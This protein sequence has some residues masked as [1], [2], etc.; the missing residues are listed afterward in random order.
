MTNETTIRRLF[1]LLLPS[2]GFW[3]EKWWGEL[4]KTVDGFA[5]E[6]WRN[7]QRIEKIRDI[8]IPAKSDFIPELEKEFFT[9]IGDLTTEERRG[10]IYARF[11]LIVENKTR[12]EAMQDILRASGFD[13]VVIRTLGSNG[14]NESPYDFFSDTG[15]AYWGAEEA[16]WGSE[17]FLYGA[18][19][20]AGESEL[21]TNGGSIEYSTS[22][23]GAIIELEPNPDYWG[24][25]FIIEGQAGAK[26]DVPI[27]QRDV[28]FDLLYLLKPSK[29]HGILRANY[30]T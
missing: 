21:I 24:G 28:F 29:M 27:G 9:A 17:E 3:I 12:I 22:G 20:V 7:Y 11:Q 23:S 18:T 14:T 16:I 8:F 1:K 6:F 26:I 30:I 15:I 4:G 5:G 10:Q 2:G 19:Q 25:Y 13:G